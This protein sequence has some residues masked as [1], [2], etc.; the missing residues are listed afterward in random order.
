[1]VLLD[2]LVK[3]GQGELVV[4]HFDHGIRPDSAD[5]ALFVEH[6]A[7]KYELPFVSRREE[8]GERAGEELARRR[9]YAFLRSEAVKFGARIVTAHHKN[10]LIET[11]AINISR[12]TG[13]RGLAVFGDKSIIRPL[14][15]MEKSELHEYALKNSLEWAEDS[16]NRQQ[17]Y[18][19]NRLRARLAALSGQSVQN[20][21]G[22]WR[23]QTAL[24]DEIESEVATILARPYSR[25]FFTALELPEALELLRGMFVKESQTVFTRPQ[26]ERALLAIKTAKPGVLFQVGEGIS[27][28]FSAK[29]FVVV[30]PQKV[31]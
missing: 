22:L 11:V 2:M 24:R 29:S 23:R 19:R 8:L 7:A 1:M 21:E 30:L 15:A 31:L 14:L 16:T 20:L 17:M 9:R 3:R 12:G 27:L 4:A 26:L 18:L 10:D 13:W 25:Y 5:D 6:L 28:Q